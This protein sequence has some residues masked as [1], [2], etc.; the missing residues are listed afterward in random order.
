MTFKTLINLG[1]FGKAPWDMHTEHYYNDHNRGGHHGGHHGGSSKK[2]GS[3]AAL[4]ALTLL[5]FLFLLNVMQQSLQDNNSTTPTTTAFLLRETDQLPIVLDS[6]E[7]S[8]KTKDD[9][10][11][12]ASTYGSRTPTKDYVRVR[13]ED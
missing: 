2:G 7:D 4:S 9:L 6:K 5:A 11:Y 13:Y 10:A 12:T 8:S 3:G 1:G